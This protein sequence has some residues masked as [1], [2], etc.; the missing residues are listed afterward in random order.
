MR[1]EARRLS[2]IDRTA[3]D[4]PRGTGDRLARPSA[5]RTTHVSR[6]DGPAGKTMAR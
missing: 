1:N 4:G 2:P 3:R 6:A 5:A